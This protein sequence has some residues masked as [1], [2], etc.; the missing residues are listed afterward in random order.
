[1]NFLKYL[2]NIRGFFYQYFFFRCRPLSQIITGNGGQC[3]YH[4]VP[5]SN[6]ADKDGNKLSAQNYNTCVLHMANKL[7]TCEK[8]C[9]NQDCGS[10]MPL[11]AGS[12]EGNDR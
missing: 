3:Y 10:E 7:E 2:Q 9:R 5:C 8:C 6:V 12:N 4:L 1:M 11:C